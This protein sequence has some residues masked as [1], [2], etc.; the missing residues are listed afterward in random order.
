M[1]WVVKTLVVLLI[2][3]V[4]APLHAA[5]A[6]PSPNP[7]EAPLA[8]MPPG[9]TDDC[10]LPAAGLNQVIGHLPQDASCPGGEALI[11]VTG[12]AFVCGAVVTQIASVTLTGN[13]FVGG[14]SDGTVVGTIAVVMNPP[15]PSFS[16]TL[17]VTGTDA[18]HFQIV[19]SNLETN[20]VVP[21]GS[22][23]INIAATQGGIINSPFVQA[24]APTG[25]QTITAVSL[26]NTNFTGESASGTVVGAIS[27]TMSSASPAFSGS[28]SLT[29]ADAAIFKI[30][31]SNLE[32]QGTVAN[33]T[34]HLSIVATQS[35]VVGSPFTQPETITGVAPNI[36]SANLSAVAFEGGSATGTV[37]G[38]ISAVMNP[39]IPGFSGTYSLSGADA[40]HFQ[41]VSGNL[42]TSGTVAPGTYSIN[43]VAT[44]ANAA[45]SPFT[46]AFTITG[47]PTAWVTDQTLEMP[48]YC[49]NTIWVNPSPNS[50]GSIGGGKLFGSGGTGAAATPFLL[51]G[52]LYTSQIPIT[53]GTCVNIINSATLY[54]SEIFG[55]GSFNHPLNMVGTFSNSPTGIFVIRST[56]NTGTLVPANSAGGI[57]NSAATK[58]QANTLSAGSIGALTIAPPTDYIMLDGINFVV[59]GVQRTQ[60]GLSCVQVGN[61]PSNNNQGGL[62]HFWARHSIVQGCGGN[63]FGIG[64]TDYVS[65]QE[66]ACKSAAISSQFQ[67][68]CFSIFESASAPG[69]VP[70]GYDS[71]LCTTMNGSCFHYHQIY[72]GNIISDPYEAAVNPPTTDGECII[73]DTSA[74]AASSS[75]GGIYL[76]RALFVNNVL[77]HCGGH[78]FEAFVSEHFDVVNNTMVDAGFDG[79]ND[80]TGRSPLTL[81]NALDG[82]MVN[83]LTYNIGGDTAVNS[84]GTGTTLSVDNV[85]GYILSGAGLPPNSGCPMQVTVDGITNGVIST[86][87]DPVNV[88]TSPGGLSGRLTLTT[89][90]SSPHGNSGVA[91]IA[92]NPTNNQTCQNSPRIF[93]LQLVGAGGLTATSC[94]NWSQPIP[95]SLA[96]QF[97][98]FFNDST[99]FWYNNLGQLINNN[100]VPNNTPGSAF[101][102][103]CGQPPTTGS[104]ANN[105]LFQD[106]LL[107]QAFFSV[108]PG[109]EIVSLSLNN[110]GSACTAKEVITLA[111]GSP[112]DAASV[113]VDSVASGQIL[114]YHM[115]HTGKYPSP[116]TTSFTEGSTTGSCSGVTFSLAHFLQ[117]FVS[118]SVPDVHL[119]G[120]SPA[121]AV[122][123]TSYCPSHN[124]FGT[125]RSC[126]TVNI[127]AY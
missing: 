69:Y 14:T 104:P 39:G 1:Y 20:G 74:L 25:Q 91:V 64:G 19:G 47:F 21:S 90:V 87:I 106:P 59:D 30:V 100:N 66:S 123:N 75:N 124:F 70:T 108:D 92:Q 85:A 71:Q 29:G 5:A 115:F 28:L 62:T 36:V 81:N 38:A 94:V 80:N 57:V 12:G 96:N 119:Q 116:S 31:G 55:N 35:G 126:P 23:S 6:C 113:Q 76:Y 11:G 103:D 79:R 67:D 73:F 83:N 89:S 43:I 18:T 3:M 101:C 54:D 120:G 84:T 34:Y 32:T 117:T 61:N 65:M 60:L 93:S 41:I 42:E 72:S 114:T 26:S 112:S 86:A 122:G 82:V 13:T 7:N 88:S 77:F 2:M 16:G 37:V 27:A 63:G 17:S 111:G 97:Q 8:N 50:T 4:F 105:I 68:S 22:Y 110:S 78:G 10:K 109:Y 52:D 102:S 107:T 46:Q 49:A 56:D 118:T 44:Q 121:L 48:Y 127:G 58:W 9:F 51:A 98:V 33:G 95:C 53:P 99:L 45:N 40:A 24:E 15:S 125:A